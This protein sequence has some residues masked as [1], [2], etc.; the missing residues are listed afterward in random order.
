MTAHDDPSTTA[1]APAPP[2]ASAATPS[3]SPAAAPAPPAARARPYWRLLWLIPG[4][5]LLAVGF[6][7]YRAPGDGGSVQAIRA[8]TRA[9]LAGEASDAIARA[10]FTTP[11]YYLVIHTTSTADPIKTARTC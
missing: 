11:D 6:V 2:S 8:S 4:L 10:K 3:P 1:A 7:S 9:G 5:A